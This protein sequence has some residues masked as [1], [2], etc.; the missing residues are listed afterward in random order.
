MR[1]HPRSKLA[2]AHGRAAFFM[3]D[4]G[5]RGAL[6]RFWRR[7][8]TAAVTVESEGRE[9]A[10]SQLARS[11]AFGRTIDA[12]L[13]RAEAAARD[14]RQESTAIYRLLGEAQR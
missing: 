7:A 12:A 11:W 5:R 8:W 2:S 9:A 14:A 10:R 13:A 6:S 4:T 1:T 3:G